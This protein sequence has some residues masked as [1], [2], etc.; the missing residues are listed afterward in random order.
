MTFKDEWLV[1]LNFHLISACLSNK[2]IF[3]YTI[4]RIFVLFGFLEIGVCD[5]I[6]YH[7][8]I[9]LRMNREKFKMKKIHILNI[10]F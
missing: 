4:Y 10:D 6:E 7:R 5:D 9:E 2:S 3:F 8:D 1:L